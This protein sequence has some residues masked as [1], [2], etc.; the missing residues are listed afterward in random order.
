MAGRPV[1]G[2]LNIGDGGGKEESRLLGCGL[3]KRPR[4]PGKGCHS[5]PSKER[6]ILAYGGKESGPRGPGFEKRG[7][8]SESKSVAP[9]QSRILN[10]H[11][12]SKAGRFWKLLR[13]GENLLNVPYD[14][15][16]SSTSPSPRDGESCRP[17]SWEAHPRNLWN[18]AF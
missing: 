9:S 14:P 2:A 16:P 7:V 12:T 10:H 11:F 15:C 18:E 4:T 6:G 5:S 13:S 3:E 17:G 8:A 1:P